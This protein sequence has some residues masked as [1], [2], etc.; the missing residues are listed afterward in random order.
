MRWN[1]IYKHKK[2]LTLNATYLSGT[3]PLRKDY[4]KNG[5]AL[6]RKIGNKKQVLL[7]LLL[8]KGIS[9]HSMMDLAAIGLSEWTQ[10]KILRHLANLRQLR[11]RECLHSMKKQPRGRVRE[12]NGDKSLKSF[13]PCYIF[14]VTSNDGFYS[15]PHSLRK[16]GLKLVC[17]LNIVYIRKPQV[18]ELSRLCPETSTKLY[19]HEFGF[20]SRI[21]IDISSLNIRTVIICGGGEGVG[22]GVGV[23][24][25]VTPSVPLFFSQLH[26]VYKCWL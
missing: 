16:N 23:C 15:S 9:N 20:R 4:F 10:Q 26:C 14:T 1:T 5:M 18:W 17:S 3:R 25:Y 6:K 19:I 12:H 11:Y 21:I 24:Y 2:W 7:A 8:H 22:V 13:A